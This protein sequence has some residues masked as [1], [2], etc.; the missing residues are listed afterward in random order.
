M[1]YPNQWVYS[2]F[3]HIRIG[4]KSIGAFLPRWMYLFFGHISLGLGFVGVY[5]PLLPTTPFILLA[6]ACY[7]RGS[8]RFTRW[9]EQHP[10]FGPL[11]ANWEQHG[12]ISRC[13]KRIAV[14]TV[15]IGMAY[16]IWVVPIL[17]LRIMLACIGIAVTTFILTRPDPPSDHPHK[18]PGA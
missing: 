11:L 2:F 15:W 5:L 3:G 1:W 14:V 7:K 4:F 10:R 6:A 8:I 18:T 13:A 17:G 12:A 16:S 9:I